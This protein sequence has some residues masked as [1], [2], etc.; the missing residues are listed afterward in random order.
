VRGTPARQRKV[1]QRRKAGHGGFLLEQD[2]ARTW[3]D[4]PPP[5][6]AVD[7]PGE[8]P[9]KRG[10][11]RAIA[12]DQRQPVARCHIEVEVAEQPS[13]PLDETKIFKSENRCCHVGVQ[14][15]W[16]SA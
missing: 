7:L 11:A 12:A 8:K 6:V 13:R 15:S 2:H 4:G 16:M 1:A 14:I 10:L 3:H 9:E 5:L